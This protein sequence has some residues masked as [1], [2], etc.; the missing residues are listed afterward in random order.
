[1]P[2]S[3]PI[4][5]NVQLAIP[6]IAQN[7]TLTRQQVELTGGDITTTSTTFVDATGMTL[8]VARTIT[9]GIIFA[10]GSISTTVTAGLNLFLRWVDGATNKTAN[11]ALTAGATSGVALSGSLSSQIVKIQWHISVG[12]TG[13]MY[14]GT[15]TDFTSLLQLAEIG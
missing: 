14:G 3:T 1:M 9:G 5:S 13:T 10:V 2:T 15:T 11:A 4:L 6:S 7:L 12:A 8:T